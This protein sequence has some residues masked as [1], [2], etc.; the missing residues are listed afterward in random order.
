MLFNIEQRW[1][2]FVLGVFIA[3]IGAYFHIL[4]QI[5]TLKPSHTFQHQTEIYIPLNINEITME[6]LCM[7]PHIGSRT[8]K[9]IIQ[10]RNKRRRFKNIDELKDVKGIGKKKFERLKEFLVVYPPLDTAKN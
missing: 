3:C 10:L 7:L 2:V 8:A 9:K 4:S 5:R 1:A 6:E